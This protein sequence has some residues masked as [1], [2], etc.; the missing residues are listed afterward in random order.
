MH[1]KITEDLLKFINVCQLRAE[2][3]NRVIYIPDCVGW[4]GGSGEEP[5]L[6]LMDAICMSFAEDDG[7]FSACNSIELNEKIHTK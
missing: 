5:L 4:G 7:I 2:K 6:I 1:R 3:S